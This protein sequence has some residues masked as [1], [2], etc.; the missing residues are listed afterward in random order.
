MKT[1]I[2]SKSCDACS[3]WNS[4]STDTGECRRRAPQNI[5][6]KINEEVSVKAQFPSTVKSDWC[7]DFEDK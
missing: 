6:F 2:T 1:E 3:H 4:E 7:G 5:V